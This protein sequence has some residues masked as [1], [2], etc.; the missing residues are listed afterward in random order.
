M[1]NTQMMI[2]A[3]AMVMTN[4]QHNPRR[5]TKQHVERIGQLILERYITE[6]QARTFR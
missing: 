4:R 3:T 2:N 6:D 5:G 1:Y